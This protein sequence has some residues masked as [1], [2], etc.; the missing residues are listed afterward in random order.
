MVL[1]ITTCT[2]SPLPLNC[3]VVLSITLYPPPLSAMDSQVASSSL[4][5]QIRLQFTSTYT[6][7]SG[8]GLQF[9]WYLHLEQ[10]YWVIELHILS[11]YYT[12]KYYIYLTVSDDTPK[13]LLSSFQTPCP[14]QLLT[15]SCYLIFP[16][17]WHI[18]ITL[19][20]IYPF[21]W[22]YDFELFFNVCGPLWCPLL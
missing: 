4:P 5:P 1:P 16:V 7:S 2:F 13:W 11:M 22:L 19:I 9:S 14:F 15:L 21:T 6:A 20:C 3:Q 12:A 8:S 10:N 17:K 18:V